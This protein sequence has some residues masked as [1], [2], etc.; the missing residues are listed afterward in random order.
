MVFGLLFLVLAARAFQL[1]YLKSDQYTR[2]AG[3]NQGFTNKLT[4][5]RGTIQDRKGARLAVSF[6]ADSV[7]VEPQKVEDKKKTA[8]ALARILD[9]NAVD[10]ETKLNSDRRFLWV[11][12]LPPEEQSK[13]LRELELPGVGFIPESRRHYP[14]GDMAAH[15]LG[16][17]GLDCRGLEGLELLYDEFLKG[18]AGYLEGE[19]DAHGKVFFPNG[20]RYRDSEPG[21]DLV[22][23]LDAK[24]QV[25]TER[26]LDEAMAE[27]QAKSA[28]ALVMD[29][30]RGEILALV[31]RPGFCTSDPT[32]SQMTDRR[33]RAVTDVFEPG[34]TFKIFTMAAALEGGYPRQ[35]LVDCEQGAWRYGGSTL[36]DT[37]RYGQMDL[38]RIIKVSSNIGAAKLAI[39]MGADSFY[40][41]IRRFG[42]GSQTG[43]GLPGEVNGLLRKPAAWS[44]VG[45]ATRAFGQGIAVTS[46]QLLSAF[47]AVVN[48]GTLMKPYIVSEIIEADGRP[49]QV[50]KPKIVRRVISKKSSE[51][52]IRILVGVT[53][54]GGT[55]TKAAIP[56]F[57]VVGKTGTAQKVDRQSK[58]YHPTA[59][60]A[61]FIG[62]VPAKNPVISILVVLDEPQG[63]SWQRYGGVVAAPVFRKIA[64][65][66]LAYLDVF[67]EEP[68]RTAAL[69]GPKQNAGP[70]AEL[71]EITPEDVD[72]APAHTPLL[73]KR[74]MPDFRG[75]PMRTALRIAHDR[76]IQLAVEGSGRVIH[77]EPQPGAL[78]LKGREAK[79]VLS[80]LAEGT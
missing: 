14:Q 68:S 9:L 79:V 17:V 7:F 77:Q 57:E 63:E 64:V 26:A 55:G 49:G 72:Q 62:C 47:N 18:K 21:G 39:E 28:V 5:K 48:G 13:R 78:M 2:I 10:L 23:T 25:F 71:P 8:A 59:R 11:K 66:S 3:I 75:L 51:E 22:L 33:N 45:L 30:H 42:F 80:S 20:V 12:R 32:T 19:R 40:R 74:L 73:A 24:I 35:G 16:F 54:E 15:L 53:E 76:G 29:P 43:I 69:T 60:V 4:H 44:R 31:S 61:S 1:Q 50:N 65:Q 36:H 41:T 70:A 38:A 58:S 67:P 37:H 46:I 6:D 34:S 56:G 52:A 27:T